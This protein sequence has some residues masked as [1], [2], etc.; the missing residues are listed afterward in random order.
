MA[1]FECV[2]LYPV[3][4]KLVISDSEIRSEFGDKMVSSSSIKKMWRSNTQVRL[5]F[6]PMLH[7]IWDSEMSLR[8]VRC[9]LF[10]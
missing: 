5:Q 6:Q 10:T 7:H 3:G 2:V 1:E 8:P 9:G 4:T